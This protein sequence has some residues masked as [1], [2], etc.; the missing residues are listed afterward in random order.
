MAKARTGFEPHEIFTAVSMFFTPQELNGA[1]TNIYT[2]AAFFPMAAKKLP[3]IEFGT[4]DDDTVFSSYLE[5]CEGEAFPSNNML[6]DMARGI[7]AAIA[8][9]EW[10]S[11]KHE[12]KSSMAQTVYM[13]G[14]VW[15]DEV[16]PLNIPARGFK[17]Y[18]SSDIIVKP[19]GMDNGYYGVSLKKK[20]QKDAVDPTMINKAFDTVINAEKDAPQDI[21]KQI[22]QLKEDIVKVRRTFFAGLVRDAV[23]EKQIYLPSSI[24]NK[25]DKDLFKGGDKNERKSYNF[26]P[27]R[28]YINTKA[29]LNMPE[30]L[31]PKDTK[32][33]SQWG[34]PSE[35][36]IQNGWDNYGDSKMGRSE[37]RSRKDSMR[38]W[39]NNRLRKKNDLYDNIMNVLNDDKYKEMIAET[40]TAVT[41]RYDILEQIKKELGVERFGELDIGFALVTGIGDATKLGDWQKTAI[42]VPKGKAFDIECVQEGLAHM[43][44]Y[45]SNDK[46][47]FV[48]TNR[49]TEESTDDD[50][51]DESDDGD[52]AAKIIFNLEKK[53][54][55]LMKME[56]RFKGGFTSQPQFFGVFSSHFKEVLQ[57]KCL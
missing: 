55:P 25:N 39:V 9:K 8:I 15:P 30:I 18:N 14:K 33:K 51:I 27:S 20:P 47:K 4:S 11:G 49:P 52:G 42:T 53:G 45:D 23:K 24:L 34:K 54:K 38:N 40:L 41:M 46:W 3:K 22:K 35:I 10:L 56:L 36:G 29:G 1:I 17:S 44:T 48:I 13:T 26:N 2:L 5:P 7:S 19:E 6:K 12:V 31:G 21:V 43:D 57:G 50:L 28:A 32:D 16:E 37:L